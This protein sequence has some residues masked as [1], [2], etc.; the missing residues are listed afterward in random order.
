MK[1]KEEKFILADLGENSNKYWY[2]E[3]HD[4]DL[5]VTKY[6]RVGF[7][8][9]ESNFPSAGQ[10]FYDKKIK[11]KTKKGYSPLRTVDAGATASTKTVSNS[12]LHSLVHKQIAKGNPQL[13]KLIQRLVDANVHNI[14][15]STNIT[16][17]SATGLFSTPLGIVT[18]DAI[19]EARE[20]LVE[21]KRA[22]KRSDNKAMSDPVNQYLRL[23]PQNIGMRRMKP[24]E[25]FPD[26]DAIKKQGD[27]L[28]SLAA[29]YSAMLVKP[30]DAKKDTPPEE[31]VFEVELDVL[32]DNR[33]RD[34]LES[35]YENTKKRMHGYDSI[36]VKEIYKVVIVN[37]HTE[38]EKRGKALGKI[39]EVYHGTSQANLLSI[40]KSGLKIS[41]P[42]T[43]YIAGKMFGN[44]I[45]G[46][47]DSSKSL[48][49]TYGRWGGSS[50]DSG[51][52]FICDFAMGNIYEPSS[53]CSRPPTGYDSVWAR[54]SK[55]GLHHDELIVYKD[56][57]VTVKYL[58]ECK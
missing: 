43:A 35:N 47:I 18:Q 16:F 38:F 45:Y 8:G 44:G 57:Q 46:A 54:A 42:S 21:I 27:I 28:D 4:D 29:S 58:L 22:L 33:E 1:I 15:S 39:Q 23:V 14:T 10:S 31:K 40:L 7:S 20:L 19:D 12:S 56:H 51:W 36:K 53:T 13:S 9:Q 52:L 5:V 50:S 2:I 41:P 34:R 32:S 49:Y 11:E 37:M 48:G 30:T 26:D 6:G 3:L 25:V 24:I 55:V 17:N